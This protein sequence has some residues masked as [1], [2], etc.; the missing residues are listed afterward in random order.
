MWVKSRPTLDFMKSLQKRRLTS[1]TVE[2]LS[3][4]IIQVNVHIYSFGRAHS[5]PQIWGLKQACSEHHLS[6][7]KMGFKTAPTRSLKSGTLNPP[8]SISLNDLIWGLIH[9]APDHDF[10]VCGRWMQQPEQC[11]TKLGPIRT[12]NL[13]GA[14]IHGTAHGKRELI[15]AQTLNYYPRYMGHK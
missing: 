9:F 7:I 5:G 13:K 2:M 3:C 11:S 14:G 4:L 10:N 8:L 15:H 6:T 1:L 12:H